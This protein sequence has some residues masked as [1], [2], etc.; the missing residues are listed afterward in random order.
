MPQCTCIK[1]VSD[2]FVGSIRP[3]PVGF[4][5]ITAYI[6]RMGF[7]ESHIYDSDG[8]TTAADMHNY[9]R[10]FQAGISNCTPQYSVGCNYLSTPEIPAS[11]TK[12]HNCDGK[13]ENSWSMI[14]EHY[15]ICYLISPL[16]KHRPT[17][18]FIMFTSCKEF[19]LLIV[20]NALSVNM[21]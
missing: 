10:V 16:S 18:A 9:R 17:A 20:I 21:P 1:P 13:A 11:S 3:I 2:I 6:R 15:R 7:Y 12:V 19:E 4:R 8:V 5:L 14:I